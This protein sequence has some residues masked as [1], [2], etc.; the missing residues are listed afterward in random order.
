MRNI[1]I[2]NAAQIT[3]F[4]LQP[5][6]ANASAVEKTLA[7]ARLLPNVEAVVVLCKK[8]EA[9]FG[10]ATA[11]VKDTWD[12]KTLFAE[13]KRLAA[14][15]DN[16][17]YYFADCPL[18]DQAL[19]S[20]MF[21]NHIRYFADYTFA[22][23]YPY[24]LSVEIIKTGVVDPLISL[25]KDD[26][27]LNRETVFEVMK[28]DVNA[29]DIETE[30]APVD[31]RMLRVSLAA[32]SKRDF[33]LLGD[34]IANNGLDEKSVL[35][36]IIKKPEILR[37]LP[38]FFSLQIVEGCPQVCSY[39]PYPVFRGDILGKKAEMDLASVEK[40]IGEISEFCP[41]AVVSISLWGEPA[42]HS[43]IYELISFI[44]SV[45][46]LSLVI[47]TS[48]IGWN[49]EKLISLATEPAR[50]PSWIV[51]LDACG[52]E[53]YR[54]LRG[55]GFQEA[56]G[57]ARLLIG[58]AKGQVYVQA[59]RM[60]EN[61]EALEGFFREWKKETEH[62]IIQ[63]YDHFSHFL[64]DRRVTDLSPLQ[65]FPCWHLKRDLSILIDGT[66][67]LCREDVKNSYPL[68]NILK[69]PLA[70]IWQR[71]EKHYHD[72]IKEN[73]SPLCKECDEYYTFN[74]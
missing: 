1:A 65:R 15:Y 36:V 63:K 33:L 34:V 17:F 35:D 42:L 52:E 3:P 39:C 37:T 62:L 47:E 50:F 38:A 13:M 16:I 23:G 20:R 71:A 67:P 58:L 30:I 69:E 53:E 59:V 12:A 41:D 43:K 29:F 66:V 45:E 10:S 8:K 18:L 14:G 51:S 5:V 9:A 44:Q 54:K 32:D 57:F 64:P 24:G 11:V 55:D 68:G 60:N 74:F 61:E 48:G 70:T 6:M 7:F 21:E 46:G 49:R 4:A 26:D 56:T 72:H 31:C 27:E 25:A 19:A 40:I 2:I 28:R 22:D 73:Y